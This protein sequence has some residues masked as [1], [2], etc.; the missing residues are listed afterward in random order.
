VLVPVSQFVVGGLAFGTTLALIPLVTR[1]A[2]VTE[3][4]AAP[5]D[6]RLHTSPTPYLGGVAI[7]LAAIGMSPFLEEWKAEAVVILA[8]A[9]LLAIVGLLDDMRNLSPAPRLAVEVL[10]ALLA[11]SAG[12][13]V[14]LFGG[15]V[16]IVLTVIW[17]VGVTNAFNIV[18][19][20]DG[21]AGGIAAAT[22]LGL[23]VAAGLEEQVLVGGMAALVAG[24]CLGFL[25]HNWHPAKIFMGDAGTLPLGYL[26]AAIALKLRFPAPHASSIAAVVL[27]T[28][29]ALFDT[30]LVVISRT[31]RNKPIYQGGT[32]HTSHRLLRL[33]W[34]THVV[35]GLITAVAAGAAALGVLVGRGVLP[36]LPVMAPGAVIGIVL[37][38][39][40]L[41]LPAEPARS[42]P[43]DASARHN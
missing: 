39:L 18:D 15:P 6:D 21:A 17:L 22:A 1:V 27:F 26:L 35:A 25:V 2:A 14:E 36:A 23:A 40:L 43:H 13:H 12:A 41:R 38:G 28:A 24:A 30:T 9:L 7:I 33:G 31:A 3:I 37:L 29:P 5:R 20:M 4:T 10:A 8:G 16:D 42:T 19:N 34:S 32:D 11:A